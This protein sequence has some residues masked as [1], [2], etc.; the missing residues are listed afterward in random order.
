MSDYAQG[1]GDGLGHQICAL[2]LLGDR[3]ALNITDALIC[4]Y[5]GRE[6]AL[7]HYSVILEELRFSTDPVALDSLSL[8]EILKRRSGLTKNDAAAF[9]RILDNAALLQIGISDRAAIRSVLVE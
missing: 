1:Q 7:L 8:E 3:V 4:Q 9:Q 5:E 2:P 6:N